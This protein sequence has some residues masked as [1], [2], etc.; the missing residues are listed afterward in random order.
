M[1]CSQEIDNI[2]FLDGSFYISTLQSI[3]N[4]QSFYH[5]RTMSFEMPKCKSFEIDDIVDFFCAES[6]IINKDIIRGDT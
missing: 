3:R 4:N 5:H 6:M 2:Y 1:T